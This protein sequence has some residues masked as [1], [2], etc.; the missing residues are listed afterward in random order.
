LGVGQYGMAA[1]GVQNSTV[2]QGLAGQ[3]GTRQSAYGGSSARLE[4][5]VKVTL[6]RRMRRRLVRRTSST[7]A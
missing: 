4:P 1:Q 3:L 6:P 2:G 7:R 5:S